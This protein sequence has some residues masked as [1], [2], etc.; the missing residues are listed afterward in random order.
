MLGDALFI[1]SFVDSTNK[2]KTKLLLFTVA[3]LFLFTQFSCKKDCI[4]NNT[5]NSQDTC[6]FNPL[7]GSW[8]AVDSVN[9]LLSCSPQPYCPPYITTVS[10]TS[11]CDS[12]TVS[13]FA[14]SG[15]NLTA[16]YLGTSGGITQFQFGNQVF[17][18]KQETY[19]IATG[20]YIK[21]YGSKFTM[22]LELNNVIAGQPHHFITN[23]GFR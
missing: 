7:L 12:I 21:F 2:M 10:K 13:N 6:L 11:S 20:S 19:N 16:Y 4:C 3:L 23:G 14:T 22:H 18:Y 15:V 1:F 5:N 8:S 9:G 17:P